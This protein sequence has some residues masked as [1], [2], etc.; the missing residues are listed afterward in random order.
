MTLRNRRAIP[1][2]APTRYRANAA[3]PLLSG[4]LPLAELPLVSVD[5]PLAVLTLVVLSLAVLPLAVLP[6][7]SLPL[8]SG[9]LPL[10]P[11]YK[12][13]EVES[14]ISAPSTVHSSIQ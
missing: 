1:N 3:L 14:K 8:V 5:L 6:L 10:A 7:A 9:S 11:A 4:S 12:F 2:F 13:R